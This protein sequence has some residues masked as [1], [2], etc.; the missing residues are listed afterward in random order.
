VAEAETATEK[1]KPL[2]EPRSA[3]KSPA[4]A[5]GNQKPEP[6]AGDNASAAIWLVAQRS[7]ALLQDVAEEVAGSAGAA[8]AYI[9]GEVWPWPTDVA[10]REQAKALGR[11]ASEFAAESWASMEGSWKEA[12]RKLHPENRRSFET[13]AQSARQSVLTP[14]DALR[15]RLEAIKAGFLERHPEHAGLLLDRDPVLVALV[16]SAV[17]LL[18]LWELYVC[19]CVVF[20]TLACFFSTVFCMACLP[21]TCCCF[22]ARRLS[23]KKQAPQSAPPPTNDVLVGSREAISRSTFAAN[24]GTAAAG[25]PGAKESAPLPPPPTETRCRGAEVP[26]SPPPQAE[27]EMPPRPKTAPPAGEETPPRPKTAP[28]AGE[29]A[30]S[31]PKAATPPKAM[32]QEAQRSPAVVSPAP[33]STISSAGSEAP[34]EGEE[35]GEAG[36]QPKRAAAKGTRERPRAPSGPTYSIRPSVGTWLQASPRL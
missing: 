10:G 35:G 14:F 33:A 17:F 6:P 4:P 3:P 34:A 8:A 36:A 25:M 31:E 24:F 19:W 13:M 29:A 11:S 30:S 7:A 20:G 1:G 23:G 2:A 9:L 32:T 12:Y 16:L 5:Q 28:P 27:P 21:C 22:C 18:A 15:P 26:K